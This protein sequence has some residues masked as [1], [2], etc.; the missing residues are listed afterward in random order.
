MIEIYTDASVAEHQAVTTCLLLSDSQFIGYNVIQ[1]IKIR[2]TL[3]S[4]LL[5]IK[6]ALAYA[7]S[8]N[9]LQDFTTLY[10]DSVAAVE[11][12]NREDLSGCKYSD[13]VKDI[14]DIKN[15]HNITIKYYKGHQ[16]CHNPNKVVDLVSKSVLRHSLKGEV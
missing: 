3:Q 2:S 16:S 8:K 13:I 6:E 15:S 10:C 1:H 11:L 9:L 12:V 14:K 7:D 5:G 4:E